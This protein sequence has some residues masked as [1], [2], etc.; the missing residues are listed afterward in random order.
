M[1]VRLSLFVL[2]A[3]VT[4]C[5]TA[6]PLAPK[7]FIDEQTANTLLAVAS[8][9]VFARDRSDIAARARDYVNLVGLE[10]D[11]SG[12]YRQY[13]LT[14]RWST[15]DP[16]MTPPPPSTAGALLIIADG[17]EIELKPLDQ[18][19]VGLPLRGELLVPN[20]GAVS[21]HAYIADVAMLHFIAESRVISVRLP[22]EPLDRPFA[23]WEDGRLAL[24]QFLTHAATR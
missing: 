4:S 18:L 19:P 3:A 22:Q 11:A 14:Y 7:E 12:K 16:R 17:R 2:L 24:K 20:H 23:L 10:I 1:K 13:L 15:V 8:P 5:A 6:P 21:A 9:L